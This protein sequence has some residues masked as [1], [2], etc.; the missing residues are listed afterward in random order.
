M[1]DKEFSE[2]IKELA[3][4]LQLAKG[5]LTGAQLLIFKGVLKGGVDFVNYTL[6]IEEFK[7]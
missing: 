6:N 5:E 1:E 2:L 4:K 3:N 7:K